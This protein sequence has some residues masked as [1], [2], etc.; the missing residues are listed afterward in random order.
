MLSFLLAKQSLTGAV[1]QNNQIGL[2]S[3]KLVHEDEP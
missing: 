2:L 3:L 1:D